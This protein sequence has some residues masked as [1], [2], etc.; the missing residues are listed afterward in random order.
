[1]AVAAMLL[2]LLLLR[3]IPSHKFFCSSHNFFIPYRSTCYNEATLKNNNVISGSNKRLV[4]SCN[5]FSTERQNAT[6][7]NDVVNYHLDLKHAQR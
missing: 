1:M 7:A 6:A 3:S 4:V 5:D 2:L